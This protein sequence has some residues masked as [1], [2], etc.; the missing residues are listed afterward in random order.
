MSDREE[1]IKIVATLAKLK[2]NKLIH[3]CRGFLMVVE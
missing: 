1:G 2:V 3:H